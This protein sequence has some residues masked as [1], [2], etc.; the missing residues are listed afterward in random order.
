MYKLS[1]RD[2]PNTIKG[3]YWRLLFRA[4]LSSSRPS[5]NEYYLS[6]G[7]PSR[8]DAEAS[9]LHNP[10]NISDLEV[11][12]ERNIEAVNKLDRLIESIQ[13]AASL[14]DGFTTKRELTR[15]MLKNRMLALEADKSGHNN[16]RLIISQ[17]AGEKTSIEQ[18][19]KLAEERNEVSIGRLQ[20][21]EAGLESQL[22]GL[23]SIK[24]A[25][26]YGVMLGTRQRHMHVQCVEELRQHF[27]T[28]EREMN[29]QRAARRQRLDRFFSIVHNSKANDAA[30]PE[31]F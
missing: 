3:S 27:E 22:K 31:P 2:I 15:Q 20:A 10:S 30:L 28:W 5:D 23:S 6:Y 12:L 25:T 14:I 29:A 19:L 8:P 18:A 11:Q 16:I 26:A 1:G 13:E 4:G 7:L 9:V 17:L 21:D 24:N